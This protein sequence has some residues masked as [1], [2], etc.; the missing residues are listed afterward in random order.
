[1]ALGKDS[2]ASGTLSNWDSAL[3]VTWGESRPSHSA[4]ETRRFQEWTRLVLLLTLILASWL[5]RQDLGFSSH[6]VTWAK[7]LPL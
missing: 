4:A 6:W 3:W 2:R 7:G 1:M 5:G